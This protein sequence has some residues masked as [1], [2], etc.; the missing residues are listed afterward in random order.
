METGS[1]K[2]VLLPPTLLERHQGS[3]GSTE[4]NLTAA[5]RKTVGGDFQFEFRI[6]ADTSRI[7]LSPPAPKSRTDNLWRTTCFE[8]FLREAKNEAYTEVNLA[9][10]SAWAIYAFEAYRS[11]GR[12]DLEAAVNA[13]SF[14]KTKNEARLSAS[15]S[16]PSLK[17]I[18]YASLCVEP[19]A[20]IED[21]FGKISYWAR[22]HFTEKPDFHRIICSSDD[23]R[24]TPR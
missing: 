23:A 10:S 16:I 18:D 11:G 5:C 17:G 1:E 19:A 6:S 3:D 20:I 2:H 12:P 14:G 4:I 13:I 7:K 9:T 21:Q 15:V 22:T 24:K 8:F